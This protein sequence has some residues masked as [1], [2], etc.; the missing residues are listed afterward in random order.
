MCVTDLQP[1]FTQI[2]DHNSM[3]FHW[4]PTKVGTKIRLNESFMCAIF[5][6]DWNMHLCFMPNFAKCAK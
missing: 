1:H 4:I 2:I 3:N 5:L 6:P